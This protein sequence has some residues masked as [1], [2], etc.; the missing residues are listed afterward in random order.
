MDHCANINAK[1]SDGQTPIHCI[2]PC[3]PGA[4]KFLLTYS[5]KADPDIL[6]NDRQSRSFPT[7]VGGGIADGTSKARLSHNQH[8][9]VLF[10]QVKQSQEVDNLFV[11]RALDSGW[12]G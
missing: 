4:A 7:M 6:T 9:E 5:D 3:A 8:S 1:D 12:R 2:I 11:E 10:F